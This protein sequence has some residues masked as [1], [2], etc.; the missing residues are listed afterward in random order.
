MPIV[1]ANVVIE[2]DTKEY[3][4]AVRNTRGFL[5]GKRAPKKA[6]AT[7]KMVK[8]QQFKINGE[9]EH[10][11]AKKKRRAARRVATQSRRINRHK[12]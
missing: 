10:S 1:G 2:T 8:T 6:V 9:V 11:P 4:T 7:P 5:R 12:R 3:F